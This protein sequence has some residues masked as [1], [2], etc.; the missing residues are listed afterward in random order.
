MQK[1]VGAINVNGYVCIFIH[2]VH[3][4][5]TFTETGACPSPV[6]WKHRD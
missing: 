2:L 6:V 1:A 4:N 3:F 5:I